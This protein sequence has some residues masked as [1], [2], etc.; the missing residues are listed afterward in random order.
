MPNYMTKIV[1]GSYSAYSAYCNTQNA[2]IYA[3]YVSKY[4]KYALEYAVICSYICKI[5]SSM[6]S[7]Y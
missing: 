1:Q 5:W 2:D 4:A 6:T 3:K 7:T